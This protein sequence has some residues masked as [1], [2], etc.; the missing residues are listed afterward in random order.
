MKS[1]VKWMLFIVVAVVSA[2]AWAAWNPE[3]DTSLTFNLNFESFSNA[4]HTTTDAKG[5]LVGT[6]SDF[7]ATDHDVFGEPGKKGYDANFAANHD[8]APGAGIHDSVSSPNDCKLKFSTDTG[9]FDLGGDT[10]QHT[11]TF[12]FNVP[13]IDG[14]IIRHASINIALNDY[15]NDLWEIRIVGSKLQFY[16]KKNCLRME[17]ADSLTTLGVT[18]NTWH[19]A[20]VVIDRTN[21]R[22]VTSPTTS[23]SAKIYIDGLEVPV[24]VANVNNQ[25]MNV[26]LYYDSPIWFGAGDREFDGLL[27]ELYLFDRDLTPVEVSI[28]NQT[29][30]TA[31]P[32]ALLPIPRSS[33]IT[34]IT[35]ANWV[36][37]AGATEQEFYF[38]EDPCNFG[39]PV[40]DN[41]GTYNKVANDTFDGP[42]QLS[43]K[44]YWRIISKVSGVNIPGPI[45]YFTSETGKALNPSPTDGQEDVD[46][47]D[48]NLS[49]TTPTP[50]TYDVYLST[51]RALVEANNVSAFIVSKTY[52]QVNDI[53]TN[54]RSQ[55]YYW[56]VNST[57]PTGN[58]GGDIWSF[59]TRPYEIVFNT[60]PVQIRVDDHD[61]P[62]YGCL[63]HAN[64]W[65]ALRAD[66]NSTNQPAESDVIGHLGGDGTVIFDF[67]TFNYDHRFDIVVV[68]QYRATDYNATNI[69][70]PIA[71][72]VHDKNGSGGS[73]KF[74]GGIDISGQGTASSG[75][76]TAEGRSGGFAGPK[77]NQDKSIFPDHTNTEAPLAD[78]WTS[79]G[80]NLA[81]HRRLNSEGG[82]GKYVWIPTAL[83]KSV[84]GPG[85]P[86]NPPYK[87]GGGGGNGGL[88]GDAG[89][90]YD[91]GVDSRGPTYGDK[92]VPVAFGGS[93]GGWGGDNSPGGCA[94]GGG[95]E[96]VAAGSVTLDVSCIINANGGGDSFIS[97]YSY[98]NGGGAGGSVKI[99]AGSSVTL[100]GDITANGGKGANAS[101]QPNNTG[102]GGGGGRVAIFYGTA[103]D[104]NGSISVTG[105]DKGTISNPP[106]SLARKGQD[107]TIFET[108]G[109]P[110]KA[111]APTP[112]NNDDTVY[113]PNSTSQPLTLKWYSG[114][115]VSSANDVVYF[116]TVNPPTTSIG[117]IT[118]V[119][120]VQK[121]LPTTIDKNKTYYWKVKTVYSGGSADSDVWKFTTVGWQCPIAVTN[122]V[123][124][125]VGIGIGGPEWDVNHDCVLNAE[126]FWYFA[127]DWRNPEISSSSSPPYAVSVGLSSLRRFASE[128]LECY[129]RTK[130]G[131][132]GW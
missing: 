50:G 51:D 8:H 18:T 65:F 25:S 10:D 70:S 75:D 104:K 26:D 132:N 130:S 47:T 124:H 113:C 11:F 76:N 27:D 131:C 55:I 33:S 110:R 72:H 62:G 9:V 3:A 103:Y 52:P 14:T 64:G 54:L 28:I 85:I 98:P 122:G 13:V 108:N 20:A 109:S 90:G 30:G 80:W 39:A 59:T 119:N 88:G 43:T 92:E 127:Q 68:P 22:V 44:Y 40:V 102:G 63:V 125:G 121:T 84:F 21:C 105:G 46:V 116:G 31:K 66:G 114:Y 71:I 107:G 99:V 120:R 4:A 100:N 115:N 74:D 117:Q 128:W 45:W 24:T 87:G 41:N 112:I 37:R 67:N 6:I 38:G 7:N 69:P 118:N 48:V 106:V 15:K 61:I 89:R 1:R 101:V 29:D 96:I 5:L 23:L 97:G 79:I 83:A 12:W 36:P 78:Y 86:V 94:G 58:V 53:T 19:H 32:I 56:R 17:T 73:F 129:G 81:V 126:D 95:I 123:S 2:S 60:R 42:L 16:H 91:F 57:Y 35:D 77:Q 34:I 93:A 111:S 49:W 82:S